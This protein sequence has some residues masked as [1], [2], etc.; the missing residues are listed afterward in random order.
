MGDGLKWLL[1]GTCTSE[2]GDDNLGGFRASRRK[3]RTFRERGRE[4]LLMKARI[5]KCNMC[6]K[7]KSTMLSTN[8]N[9]TIG[10]K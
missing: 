7:L 6:E 8:P 4:L 1:L 10:F 2:A 3:W 5:K 9:F